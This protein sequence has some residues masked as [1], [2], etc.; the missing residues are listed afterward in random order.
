MLMNQYNR[1]QFI[2]YGGIAAFSTLLGGHLLVDLPWE[3]QNP[4]NELIKEISLLTST[5][6]SELVQFYTG[7]LGFDVIKQDTNHCTFQTGR[8][9]LSFTKT[10]DSSSP[11]YH[12]AFNIPENKIKKAELW[13]ETKTPFIKPPPN[14]LDKSLQSDNIVHFRH[15]DAH[16]LFFYDPAGNVVEYIA[17]H[18]LNNRAEGD[19]SPKDVLYISEI[20]LVVDNVYDAF[21]DISIQIGLEQYKGASKNFLAIGDEYGLIIFFKKN[22]KA[23]FNK[24]ASRQTFGTQISINHKVEGENCKVGAYPFIITSSASH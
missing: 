9:L 22:T 4:K 17:R 20:G 16:A 18:P 3:S 1:R 13:Q 19:F 11:F 12:F 2:K 23:A 5:K 15:W 10:A 8:S 24:G 6:I 7:K 14:L 21:D